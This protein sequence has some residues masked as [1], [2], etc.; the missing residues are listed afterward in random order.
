LA[1]GLVFLFI[2]FGQHK[3]R[4]L[5]GDT[6]LVQQPAQ[7]TRVVSDI[8]FALDKDCDSSPDLISAG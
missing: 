7:I 5:I 2:D 8:E 6:D 3:G 1:F 4:L